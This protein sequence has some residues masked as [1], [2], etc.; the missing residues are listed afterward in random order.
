MK[1]LV[2]ASGAGLA[3][4]LCVVASAESDV[5]P[6]EQMVVTAARSPLSLSQV[7]SATTVISRQEIEQRQL[8]YV[9]D[10][11]RTVPGFSISHTGAVGS[12]TQVRVRGAEANH[13]LVLIDGVRAN[14]PGNG[15]EFRWEYLTTGNIERIE[16]VRGPQSSLWGSDAVSA[17]VHIIT[18]TPNTEPE[19]GLYVEGGSNSTVNGGLQASFGSDR[20]RF[21]AGL[22]RLATDGTNV[23][24]QGSEDDDSD[25]TT[26][27]L[28]AQF[29]ATDTVSMNFSLRAVDAYSQ[30]DPVDFFVTGLPT[31]GDRATD[32]QQIYANVGGTINTRDGQL[33]HRLGVRYFDADN[34]NLVDGIAGSSTASDRIG[35]SYQADIGLGD[36]LLSLAVEHER[37][38]FEQRGAIVFGD[39]NQNQE[40]DIT[41]LVADFQG[42]SLDKFT[43][44]LSARFDN[45]SEF[46]NATTGRLAVAYDLTDTTLLRA[47]I[48]TGQKNPTFTDRF[49]F[50]PG[51]FVGNENLKPETTTAFEVGIDHR[52]VD[53]QL[54]LQGSW[55]RQDLKD[56][57]NGFVFDPTT[58]LFTAQNIAGTSVRQGVELGL[59]W[60]LSDSFDVTAAYTYVDTTEENAN[61]AD[62]REIRR[63]RHAASLSANYRF[64]NDRAQLA[65]GADYG[66]TRTDT[67]FP[68]F[69]NPPTVVTLERHL[70]VDLTAQFQ[71]SPRVSL[72]ARGT[73]LLDEEYE[74]V[75]GYRTLGR[76]GY[77]GVRLSFN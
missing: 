21:G 13:V 46:D 77:V 37:T 73:N 27:S 63:P 34:E 45:N 1:N 31:D 50:F 67:F 56:E 8:R 61:G 6:V 49:G 12:Q 14:D 26:A 38:K 16:I 75:F 41:S 76:A 42:L 23:S 11:L 65:L 59:S 17:V 29:A 4:A 52:L 58:F 7:G 70:L 51:Q 48:G 57:I 60:Q 22:E 44:L 30:F 35:L 19:V 72:F 64:A 55:F 15:D 54:L 66:G 74:Q 53:G 20:W 25:V 32:T 40:L 2:L 47:S 24:R 69:P 68:P 62:V 9:T 71:L 10:L 28:A 39:P 18:K 33:V 3:V 36:N 43:W 5:T